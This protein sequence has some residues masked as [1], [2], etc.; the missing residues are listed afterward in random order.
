MI[1]KF[2]VPCDHCKKINEVEVDQNIHQVNESIAEQDKK[3]ATLWKA[4]REN[5]DFCS[6]VL[7]ELESQN[8]LLRE[9][10]TDPKVLDKIIE[11]SKLFIVK[12]E[13]CNFRKK[14]PLVELYKM[15][16][17]PNC[18]KGLGLHEMMEPSG[19]PAGG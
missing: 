7:E 5:N 6:G 3:I 12:C 2:K 17:C 18:K 13:K 16:I 14:G 4:L 10:Q 11:N 9:Y 1:T 8:R 15:K 19:V